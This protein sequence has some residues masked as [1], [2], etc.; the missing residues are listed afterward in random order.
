MATITAF[1]IQSKKYIKTVCGEINCIPEI[2]CVY[3]CY[4]ALKFNPPKAAL[5]VY[6]KYNRFSMYELGFMWWN[7]SKQYINY[8]Q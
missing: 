2:K 8:L 4:R 6:Y 5:P 1:D 7:V 3:L